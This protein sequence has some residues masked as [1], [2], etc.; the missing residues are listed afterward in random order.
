M[1][2]WPVGNFDYVM[3]DALDIA[4]NYLLLTGQAVL[5]KETQATAAKAI[6]AAWHRGV[7]H[8]IKLANAA[9]KAVEEK[10][11]VRA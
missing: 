9:I 2:P 7:K 11:P 8:R 5:F 4:M 3:D 10:V 6:V 1:Y